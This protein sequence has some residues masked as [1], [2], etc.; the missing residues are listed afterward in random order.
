M[1][2]YNYQ[3]PWEEDIH[4]P[5]EGCNLKCTSMEAHRAKFALMNSNW[6]KKV[7]RVDREMRKK[8][9][10]KV[11]WEKLKELGLLYPLNKEQELEQMEQ[12]DRAMDRLFSEIST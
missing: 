10:D 9:S 2:D 6:V 5:Y 12:Q 8:R 7:R 11:N 3:F 4:C 1:S